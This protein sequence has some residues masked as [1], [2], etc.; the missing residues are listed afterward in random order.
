MVGL[1]GLQPASTYD[2]IGKRYAEKFSIFSIT[3]PHTRHIR[4]LTCREHI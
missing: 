2:Y 4:G 1:E 3:V